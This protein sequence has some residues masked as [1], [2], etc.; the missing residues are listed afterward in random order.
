[1]ETAYEELSVNEA[2]NLLPGLNMESTDGRGLG[3]KQSTMR[4][5]G[6][7]GVVMQRLGIAVS[8]LALLLC[9][10]TLALAAPE[11]TVVDQ[12]GRRVT[13]PAKVQRI[14]PLGGATR[15]VVYLQAFDLVVGVEAM[16]N[17][18]PLSSGRPYNLAIR[19]RAAHLPVVGEGRQ[20]PV[21]VEAI[22]ALRPDLLI[23]AEADR[24]QAD[25]LSRIT[26]VPVL[27]LDY[28]GMGVL[29]PERVKETFRLLGSVLQ[30]E[31]R[32]RHL[33]AVLTSQ[34]RGLERRLA[35]VKAI[36]V[37]VGAVSQRGTHGITS[38][39]ADYY[40]LEVAGALN[41]SKQLKKGGHTY[42]DKEQLLVWNPAVILV[43]AA[44]AE[45]VRQDAARNHDFFNRL[46]AVRSSQIYQTLPYNNYH[47]NIEIALANSWYVAKLLHPKRFSDIDPA[48][49]SDEL[50][51]S[52]VGI[53]CY[54]Q[55]RREY[56]GFGPLQLNSGTANAR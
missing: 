55:L 50:C 44:G 2:I 1:M 9:S 31:K 15:F 3:G 29:K 51:R 21:N 52:F 23:T 34:Q 36:P 46:A 14:I 5:R 13:L 7:K 38:T 41:L 17:R 53:P 11:R 25:F 10:A 6:V 56:G 19:S 35:G 32:A 20:K 39:D 47:T 45:M 43:D 28:G 30:R 54:E 18:Q 49:K 26:G 12:L 22:I 48:K 4:S 40:P 27:V 42:I 37:Y 24:T 8:S 33:I 16:E